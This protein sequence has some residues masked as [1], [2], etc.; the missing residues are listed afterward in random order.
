M[1]IV[2][3]VLGS[4]F[5][6][7][8]LFL[9]IEE[10][11]FQWPKYILTAPYFVTLLPI[12]TIVEALQKKYIRAHYNVYRLGKRDRRDYICIKE[13]FAKKLNL[14]EEYLSVYRAGKDFKS[15][16]NRREMVKSWNDFS[17]M[18]YT[19]DYIESLGK[20]NES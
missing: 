12:A 18:G 20:G 1:T 5:V 7:G 8:G 16:P 10:K 2:L 13:S 19:K 15:M 11:D 4:W 3:V 17:R 6:F 14:P 9:L